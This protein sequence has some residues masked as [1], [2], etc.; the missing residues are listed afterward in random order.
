MA[1]LKKKAVTGTLWVAVER[2]GS[3]GI[4]LLVFVILARLLTP[5]DFGLIAMV[6]AFFAIAQTFVDS[7]MG[8]ALIRKKEITEADRSTI[9]WFNMAISIILYILLY[10]SAPYIASFYSEPIL[11]SIT[12]VMGVSV[13]FFGLGIAQRAELTQ[14]MDFKRQ[15]FAELIAVLLTSIIAVYLAY[16]GYGVW[17]LV[18]KSVLFA[19]VSSILMWVVFPKKTSF[20][21]SKESFNELFGFGSRLLLA[22]IFSRITENIHKLVIGRFFS[23]ST[24]GLVSKASDLKNSTSRI[25]TGIIQ[26]VSYPLLS[27]KQDDI[28]Q[29]KDGYRKVLRLSSA[30]VIPVITLLIIFAEPIILILFGEQW[31]GAIPFLQILAIT[32]YLYNL[33]A[34]NLN[35]LKV[36]GRSDLYLKVNIVK[37][38]ISL[39]LLFIG[40]QFG[41]MGI[42]YSQVISS[43]L[44]LGVNVYYSEKLISYSLKDQ[45]MDVLDVAKY[46][47][48]FL[49][50]GTLIVQVITISSIYVLLASFIFLALV[51]AATAI[52]FN[53]K[54]YNLIKSLLL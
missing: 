13:I 31:E 43:F 28:V 35:I 19:L 50:F 49:F 10:I 17:A 23:A 16:K 9:F 47:L 36:L 14:R 18:V 39:T 48:P 15:T 6:I 52:T 20:M 8:Q 40:L 22:S 12:R 45:F 2:F 46:L 41:I 24:L 25:I 33:H 3:T 4:E 37:K 32:G 53:M 5:A 51:Y 26:K 42:V 29:L 11:T 34:I 21:F 27:K 38:V 1:S 30:G 54:E 7:G 44:A